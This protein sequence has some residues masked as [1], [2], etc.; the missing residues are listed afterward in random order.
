MRHGDT[1]LSDT[2]LGRTNPPVSELGWQQMALAVK[3]VSPERIISSPLLRC[4]E[5]AK[6]QAKHLNIECELWQLAEEIDFGDWDGKARSELYQLPEVMTFFASPSLVNIPNGEQYS[7]FKT[8][9]TALL[10]ALSELANERILVVTHG[11][12][13]K[14]ILNQVLNINSDNGSCHQLVDVGYASTITVKVIKHQGENFYRLA[15]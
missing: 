3:S 7:E 10:N 4:A 1:T 14:E 13:M 6:H 9:I 11:G 2:L 8:R 12:V 15:I 5:F